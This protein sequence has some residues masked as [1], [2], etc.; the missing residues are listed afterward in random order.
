[1]PDDLKRRR[2]EDPSRINLGQEWEVAHW[3]KRLGCTEEELIDAVGEVGTSVRKV[4]E[5]LGIE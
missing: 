2:P 5:Y 1:M 3:C 4:K